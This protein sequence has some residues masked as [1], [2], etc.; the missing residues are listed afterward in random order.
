MGESIITQDIRRRKKSTSIEADRYRAFRD[1]IQKAIFD[2]K[3]YDISIVET[4]KAL[5]C[6]PGDSM[7]IKGRMEE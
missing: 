2:D 1:I 7:K 3:N 4:A 6:K 5:G